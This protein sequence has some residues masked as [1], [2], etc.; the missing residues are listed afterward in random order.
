MHSVPG[1][2]AGLS[3]LL[4][5]CGFCPPSIPQDILLL[6]MQVFRNETPL[7]S[8]CIVFRQGLTSQAQKWGVSTK[9]K[10][11]FGESRQ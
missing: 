7:D 4:F 5:T 3:A 1:L 2:P 6:A 9:G 8:N 11:F 10:A